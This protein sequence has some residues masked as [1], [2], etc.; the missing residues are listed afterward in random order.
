MVIPPETRPES[1]TVL[2][3][4][5]KIAMRYSSLILILTFLTIQSA[6]G[7]GTAYIIKGGPS[8]GFQQWNE[9]ERDPLLSYN[10]SLAAESLSG[11]DQFSL[12]AQIGYHNRGSAIIYRSQILNIDNRPITVP[13]D[14]FVFRNIG[15]QLGAKSRLP[16][17]STFRGY[18]SFALRGEYNISTNLDQYQEI[19][20]IARIPFY[21]F[22]EREGPWGVREIVYGVSV[23]GGLEFSFS[24]LVMGVIELSVHPDLVA[25]YEQ[26]A[27]ENVTSPITGNRITIPERSIRNTTL[28]LSIGLRLLRKVE[29]ID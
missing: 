3:F 1:A 17:N 25:Q 9:F 4:T 20:E 13:D 24:D 5:Q 8:V 15:L 11:D 26:P 29:Y 28:E 21:P 6:I 22:D 7:Q 27:L 12:F 19:N 18:Y 2:T 14:R 23:A 16:I 10:V